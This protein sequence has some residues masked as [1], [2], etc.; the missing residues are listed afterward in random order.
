MS[1]VNLTCEV[2]EG[3]DKLSVLEIKYLKCQDIKKKQQIHEQ[4]QSL[5]VEINMSISYDK[6]IQIYHSPEYK[7]LWNIN[8]EL[9][10]IVDKIET[11]EIDAK[12][13][14]R[15]NNKRFQAKNTLQK[16]FFNK[17]TNEIKL[18]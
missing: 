11:E 13:P 1:T 5:Q 2:S 7:I 15:L 17:D 4:L 14:F 12:I 18:L 6:A 16:K 10:E 3:Y 8:K 9:F